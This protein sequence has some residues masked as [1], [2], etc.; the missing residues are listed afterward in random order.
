MK[1]KKVRSVR[2]PYRRF[3]YPALAHT[4][5]IFGH[6]QILVDWPS[7]EKTLTRVVHWRFAYPALVHTA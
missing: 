7:L 6:D 1:K 5:Q 4:I 2:T 3:A